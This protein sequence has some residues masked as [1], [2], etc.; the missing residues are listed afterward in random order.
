MKGG[1]NR[2]A[3]IVDRLK[4]TTGIIDDLINAATEEL[5]EHPHVIHITSARDPWHQL[6]RHRSPSPFK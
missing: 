3:L 5:S 1:I 2:N 4:S 6:L